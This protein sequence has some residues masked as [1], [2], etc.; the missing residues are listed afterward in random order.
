MAKPIVRRSK[1]RTEVIY[2][3]KKKHSDKKV[4]I[5]SITGIVVLATSLGLGLGLGLKKNNSSETEN[6][7]VDNSKTWEKYD[8]FLENDKTYPVT[9][10][11][12]IFPKKG[13]R[14]ITD[15][16]KALYDGGIPEDKFFSTNTE[17][18]ILLLPENYD[19]EEINNYNGKIIVISEDSELETVYNEI[20]TELEKLG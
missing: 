7:T 14:V 2:N 5:A 12:D 8:H 10:V 15:L 16:I 19:K 11:F 18:K 13:W 3:K 20:K 9:T 17:A 6:T 4:V 1:K